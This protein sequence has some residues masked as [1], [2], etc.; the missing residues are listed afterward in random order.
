VIN[1]STSALEPSGT[2]PATATSLLGQSNVWATTPARIA[3]TYAG[4]AG[5]SADVVR[6]FSLREVARRSSGGDEP[7]YVMQFVVDARGGEFY[8]VRPSGL[9]VLGPNDTTCGTAVQFDAAPTSVVSGNSTALTAQ[10]GRAKRLRVRNSA[11]TVI[12]DQSVTEDINQQSAVFTL[13]PAATDTYQVE[14]TGSGTCSAMSA[15]VTV[16]VTPPPCPVINSFAAAPS[17]VVLGGSSVLSWNVSNA[18]SV[19]INGTPVPASGT[20]TVTPGSTTTYTLSATGPGGFCPQSA[21]VTVTVSL[22]FH[23]ILQ[24]LAECD[25]AR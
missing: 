13:T 21:S 20:L 17:A 24:R 22:S 4:Q 15:P 5:F 25:P 3:E 2:P 8:R 9:L 18:T 12:F 14:A 16:T 6:V 23:S 11:G 19:N 7:A 1:A 10:Y